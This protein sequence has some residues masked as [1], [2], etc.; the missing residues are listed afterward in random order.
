MNFDKYILLL[1][2]C[3]QILRF[4]VCGLHAHDA[5][6]V[7]NYFHYSLVDDVAV[8]DFGFE[9]T[10]KGHEILLPLKNKEMGFEVSS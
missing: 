10:Q 5:S 9:Q 2:P 7:E 4:R 1:T 3:L 6:L 8:A